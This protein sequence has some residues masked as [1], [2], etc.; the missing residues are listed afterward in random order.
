[1]Y[2]ILQVVTQL[3]RA[4]A[5]TLSHWL[6]RIMPEDFRTH[7][8]FLYDKSGSDLFDSDRALVPAKPSSVGDAAR[9]V[10][11]LVGTLRRDSPEIVLAHTHYAI[12][13]AV[14][15]KPLMRSTRVVAVHHWPVDR[16]PK[17][18]QA[19]LRLGRRFDAIDSEVY[20]SLSITENAGDTVIENP[21][22]DASVYT[23]GESDAPDVD[24]LVVARHS[25]EKSIDT[26][27]RAMTHLPDRHLTL[28]GAGP[29][30]E[31]LVSL[32]SELDLTSRVRFAGHLPNQYVRNLMNDCNTLILPS[33]WEAM[34][35]V[36][37]E[38]VACDATIVASD[39]AAH[40]FLF[41]N[42]AA[43]AFTPRDV[44][45]LAAAVAEAGEPDRAARCAAGR[46][47]LRDR[48]SESEVANRWTAVM[49]SVC[50]AA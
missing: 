14:L 6:E 2:R 16:Y 31:D 12:S 32:V 43:V 37:L 20:V 34:P 18:C 50:R 11:R 8:I 45:G 44:P 1:M 36:L 15:A 24:L 21:V 5:Q 38:G 22:P 28:V 47:A 41:E 35:M 27:I 42:D 25:D 3:E 10:R 7:T 30:T 29:R 48:L 4:G 17:V 13:V 26:M 40:A 33:L 46:V 23:R 19:L 39:I 49:A 9:M